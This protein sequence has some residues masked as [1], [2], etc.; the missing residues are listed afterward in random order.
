MYTS[1]YKKAS[2]QTRIH[3]K[4]KKWTLLPEKKRVIE[5]NLPTLHMQ[6]NVSTKQT[7]TIFI[8]LVDNKYN[9]KK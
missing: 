4:N 5:P 8:T 2:T 1:K 9:R 3:V 6:F 7:F